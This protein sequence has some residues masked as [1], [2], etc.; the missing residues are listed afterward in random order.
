MDS[1]QEELSSLIN[2]QTWT[3]VD[4]PPG[5]KAIH[6]GWIYKVKKNEHGAFYRL[7]SHL[8]AKGH[9]QKPG[10]DYNDTF[11]P[12]GYKV[13]LRFVLSL[14]CILDTNFFSCLS[15]ML[16][17]RESHK[18]STLLTKLKKESSIARILQFSV[19]IQVQERLPAQSNPAHEKR[20][21]SSRKD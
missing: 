18:L 5:R 9:S 16:C 7:K 8:V 4:L 3:L 13:I 21:F 11:A 10:I 6:C 15:S 19:T 14:P 1:M 17:L 20:T 2:N 12:V